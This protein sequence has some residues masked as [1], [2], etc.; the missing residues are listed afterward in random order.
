MN[1]ERKAYIKSCE[2]SELLTLTL[3]GYPQK[4]LVEGRKRELPVVIFLHGGPGSPVP[5]SVGCRGLFPE[6]TD[7]AIMVYWDQLGCGINNYRLDDG[8]TVGT[9]VKMT[10]DLIFEIKRR[11]PGNKIYLFGMS[12]GSLLA[13]K[14]AN[15][16]P[17]AVAGVL[18]YGQIVKNLFF[19]EE[20]FRTIENSSAP[21]KVKTQVREIEKSGIPSNPA[22]L[23]KT[24]QPLVN[25]MRKYTDGYRN[26]SGKNAATGEIVR[27][28]LTS[29]DYRFR[30]FI[31]VVK[32]GYAK[33]N[34][35]WAELLK[36]DLT[37]DLSKISVPYYILQGATD[38]VASTKA[39]SELVA[40]CGNENLHCSVEE[41]AGLPT[42]EASDM[43]FGQLMRLIGNREKIADGRV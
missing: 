24:L 23:R 19:C 42:K 41:N 33:N 40:A 32:N 17:E 10:V 36:T 37:E 3:N 20:V 9:F 26:R 5:F 30:D 38:I 6:F 7:R 21:E 1:K 27:G 29:P 31:A 22:D 11:F 28:M 16:A 34:S 4:V 2:A 13:V 15:A 12:W 39:V 14:A 43:L 8:F 35:L 25:C 18:V